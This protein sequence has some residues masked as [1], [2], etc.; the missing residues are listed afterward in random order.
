MS[1]DPVTRILAAIDRLRADVLARID[2]L[3]AGSES[4]ADLAAAEIIAHVQDVG[5]IEGNLGDWIGQPRSGRWIEGFSIAAPDDIVPEELLYRVV[6]GR[7][8]LSP[9]TPSGRVLWEHVVSHAAPRLLSYA[10]RNRRLQL[11]V[12]L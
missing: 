10:A 11:S 9:W 4:P 5:D 3:E 12:Q 7:D 1:D 2:R 8:Q 6:L